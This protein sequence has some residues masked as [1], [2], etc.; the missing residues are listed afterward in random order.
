MAPEYSKYRT[1]HAAV[2]SPQPEVSK[3]LTLE[4]RIAR[5]NLVFVFVEEKIL[6]ARVIRPDLLN[7]LEHFFVVLD[8]L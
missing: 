1:Y 4:S 8:G 2:R 5:A 6:L 3:L 7:A